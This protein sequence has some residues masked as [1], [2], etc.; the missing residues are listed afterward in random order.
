MKAKDNIK[1]NY[2]ILVDTLDKLR[3]ERR[4][5]QIYE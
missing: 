5:K 1:K 4:R 3:K 2:K